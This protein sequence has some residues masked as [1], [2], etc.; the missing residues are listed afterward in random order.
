MDMP[1]IH[2]LLENSAN[3]FP[4]KIALVH[5][6]V[7]ATYAQINDQAN[8]LARCL[9]EMKVKSGDRVVLLL[10]NSFEYVVA[11]YG[12]LKAGA[13]VVPFNTDLRP[14][15]IAHLLTELDCEVILTQR[16]FER[17]LRQIDFPGTGVK[18]VVVKDP[19]LEINQDVAVINWSEFDK[20]RNCSNLGLSIRP[21]Q[22]ASIIYTS[23]S[24]GKPKGVMLSHGNIVANV[25]SICQYL[26]LTEEDIQMVVQPFFYVMGK[27]LLNTHIA[28]GG[29][30]VINNKFAYPAAVIN[31]MIEER[32]TGFSGVPSTYAYLLHQSPLAASRDQLSSLRYCSQAGGHMVSTNKRKLL[33]VLPQQTALV[34]MYG[35]TEASARLSY[36]EPE[37]LEEKIESI[38]RPIPGVTIKVLDGNSNEL[39]LGE[40]GELVASGANIMQGYW[41]D[42]EATA[43]ALSSYG[44]HTGDLG[45]EDA[46]GYFFVVGRKDNQLKVSGHRINVQEIE[47]VLLSSDGVVEAVVVGMADTMLENKLVAVVC[48]DADIDSKALLGFCA[49]RLPAYKQPQEIV[50]VDSIP[51]NASGKVERKRCELLIP[52]VG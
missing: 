44:Y 24:T 40:V 11:Y 52:V 28:V 26:K 9:Q 36:V 38:G 5:G 16:K 18:Q 49:K 31:Q 17:L 41:R 35:A 27:S 6:D 22:L 25:D 29:R 4:D 33:E 32:V 10:E 34:I 48:A 47:D 50:F 23:G 12:C 3:R 7:R 13:V 51:K 1:L 14:D 2:Q 20:Q 21:D 46:D 37:K 39:P 19:K 8:R 30:L 43:K 42:P 15:G 45:Y